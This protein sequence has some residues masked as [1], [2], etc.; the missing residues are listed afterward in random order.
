[1]IIVYLELSGGND[2]FYRQRPGK[3]SHFCFDLKFKGDN[4]AILHWAT[5]MLEAE[6]LLYPVQ[7]LNI[8]STLYLKD[9]RLTKYVGNTQVWPIRS[10]EVTT[11]V[12]MLAEVCPN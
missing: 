6:R 9:G 5:Y 10:I 4:E 3:K 12:P 11:S 1:M 2:A 8:D 7:K